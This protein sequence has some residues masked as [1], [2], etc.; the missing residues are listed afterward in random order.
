MLK[1]TALKNFTQLGL[2]DLASTKMVQFCFLTV[3]EQTLLGD[4]FW[5]EIFFPVK[6]TT[7]CQFLP[8]PV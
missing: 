4:S 7:S 1:K 3:F 8:P 6:E 2:I 5:T